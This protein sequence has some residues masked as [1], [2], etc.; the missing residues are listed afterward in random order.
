[1]KR[2]TFVATTG[3]AAGALVLGFDFPLAHRFAA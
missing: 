1:M 3:A 2:A